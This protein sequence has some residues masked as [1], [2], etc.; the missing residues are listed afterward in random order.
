M[1]MVCDGRTKEK[2]SREFIYLQSKIVWA[3]NGGESLCSKYK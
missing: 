3:L 2:E 1:V